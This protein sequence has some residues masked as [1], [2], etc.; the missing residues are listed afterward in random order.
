MTLTNL[1]A[2]V[3]LAFGYEEEL[4]RGLLKSEMEGGPGK[5][6]P[7]Y[8]VALKNRSVKLVAMSLHA[9]LAFDKWWDEELG[10][11]SLWFNYVDPFTHKL[12][13][14]RFTM[15]KLKWIAQS[16]DLWEAQVTIE[17]VGLS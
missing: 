6:R 1:P 10:G 14:A 2:G 7:R 9:K 15:D 8:S 11:G 17:S 13:E 4:N 16:R 12:M 3:R 5:Q